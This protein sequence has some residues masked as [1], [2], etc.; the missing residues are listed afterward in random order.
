MKE[1]LR[2]TLQE[3]EAVLRLI[4]P[5]FLEITI[6]KSR[7]SAGHIFSGFPLVTQLNP[8]VKNGSTD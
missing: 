2:E 3:G 5:L 8:F 6:N 4:L 1:H 7:F